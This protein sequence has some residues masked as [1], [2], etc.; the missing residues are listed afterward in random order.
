MADNVQARNKEKEISKVE[1]KEEVKTKAVEEVVGV[2]EVKEDNI[3][4]IKKEIV[5]GKDEEVL[6]T[7]EEVVEEEKEEIVVEEEE[8]QEEVQQ[9]EKPSEDDSNKE[10][11]DEVKDETEEEVPEPVEEKDEEEKEV[12]EEKEEEVEAEPEPELEEKVE[13]TVEEDKEEQVKE[14]TETPK[15]EAPKKRATKAKKEK[16]DKN[17]EMTS[18]ENQIKMYEETM[19]TVRSGNIV[20][21]NIIRVDQTEVLV[22]I[23][24]KAEGVVPL[25]EFEPDEEINVGDKVSVYI[26]NREGKNG[27]PFLS[28]KRA[29]IQKTWAELEEKSS[30]NDVVQGTVLKRVKGGLI[31][32]VSG[33]NTFLPAS[34]VSTKTLPN[35]DHFVGKELDFR[36]INYNRDKENIVISRKIVI[37]EEVE[38]KKEDLMEKLQV[39]AEIDGVV[40]NI[41]EYGVFVDLG[42]IDGLLHISDMSWGHI[43]HPSEMLNIGDKIK[44]KVLD[45][46]KDNEKVS[47][48]LKQLVPH[49]WKNI[50]IKYP[51]GSKVEGKV[52]N[53]TN[54]GAF[55]ELE[56]GV[57]GLIHVSEMSWTKQITHPKQMLKVEDAVN[58]IVLNVDKDE[59]RISLGL[60]QVEPNPWLTIG[61]TH[62]V[63]STVTGKIKN[64]TNFGAFMEV[65]KDIDGLIHIS[66]LSWTKRIMHPSEVLKKG[67]EV[68]AV[69]LSIDKVMQRIALGL[70]QLQDDPWENIEEKFPINSEHEIEVI[71]IIPKGALVLADKESEIEGFIPTSHLG[72]P[73][74]EEPELAFDHNEIIPVKVIEADKENRRLIFSVKTYFFGRDEEEV[75]TFVQD[76]LEK[77]KDRR[78][79]REEAAVKPQKKEEAPI[80]DT[81]TEEEVPLPEE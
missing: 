2:E 28:K 65:E 17:E 23:G 78:K 9:E 50:E 34:Q 7:P 12:L 56:K 46:N 1:K 3:E 36:I 63:G 73:G 11:L 58:A 44:V 72:I 70:K 51:E 37:E 81:P 43:T 62:P 66:D 47:L 75:N 79:K 76:H 21:G 32:D 53:I 15:P 69:V 57:E 18:L 55:V 71:K 60:K 49:P 13:D 20:E 59:H 27:R 19:E 77:I 8:P 33:I 25:T 61:V 67:Q 22:D 16:E 14:K 35:L 54:Y 39:D 41:M 42:G 30:S 40:K 52:T 68:T 45:F 5:K 64:I 80:E 74:L 24:F 10:V 4:E 26:V 31:V 29:D 38:K 6:E 48:G